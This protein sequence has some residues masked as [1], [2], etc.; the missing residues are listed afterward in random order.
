MTK[1]HSKI[2]K[3]LLLGSGALK[4]GEAGEFDYSGSQAI[5][6][7]KEEGLRVVLVNPNIA[8][9]QTSDMLAD[10]IYFLPVT[11]YFVERVIKKEKPDG[12]LLS[13]GGQTA[14]NCGLELQKKG[15]Y[16]KYGVKVLGTST[17]AIELTEDRQ[18]FADHLRA[19]NLPIPKSQAVNSVLGAIRAAKTIGFP[20]MV[21]AAFALG[22]QKSG[23]AFSQK[24]L[25][26]IAEAAL[27][28][29]PQVLIEKYLHHYKEVE[30][31]VV[32]DRYGNCV[33]V[34][35]MEN[36]DPLGI[37][38]GDSIV[39][40][41]SQTLDN[42][43]YYELRR[44]SMK[45]VRSL[46]IIGECNVQYALNPNPKNKTMDFQVIE[47]NAR[48][49]RS[50]ALASKA[51]GYP[52]AYVA[53]KLAL[54]KSMAEI[55]NQVTKT[56]QSF[57][58]PALDYVVVKF[59]R[60]D[61]EK[62]K[63]AEEKIGSA[64]KSVGEVMAIGRSFEE[65]LQKAVRMQSG[66]IESV[67]DNGLPK[68]KMGIKHF[69]QTPT[70]KRLFAIAE[71]FARGFSVNQIY[72]LTGID[73]WFL[74]RIK[75]IVA[76]EKA[77]IK[78]PTLDKDTIYKLKLLGFSDR[79]IGRLSGKTQ[80]E[81]RKIRKKLGIKP[82]VFQID[83]LAGEA[84]AKTNYL[85]L[86]Y[87]GSHHDV[88]ALGKSGV[89]V[90]GSGPYH[91]G[92]S[93]EFDW[94]CVNTAIALQKLKRKSIIVNC[95][96]E[97]VSTDYDMSDRLYFEDL[98]FETVSD[99]YEYENPEGV[100][101]SVGGQRPNNLAKK[102]VREGFRLLGT[103]AESIDQAEN[104][105]KFSALL[106][107]LNIPQPAWDS[108]KTLEEAEKFAQKVGFPVLVRPSYV[109]SGS[110]MSVCYNLR[111][112]EDFIR[113]AAVV[114]EE[115]PVTI[116]KFIINAKELEFDAV[117]QNGEI[118]VSAIAEHV[119]NAG[120]HSGDATIV[121]PTQRV[122]ASTE[123]RLTEIAK[124]LARELKITGPFNIQFLV[125]DGLPFVI[126]VNVRASRTFPLLSKATGVNF[127]KVC[128][129][130]F[131]GTAKRTVYEYPKAVVVKSPQFSFARLSGADPILQVEM[132]STG[133]VACFGGNYDRALLKSV[134]SANSFDFKKKA[135]LL[136]LGG[137]LNK[138]K[139]L[140][141]A[142]KLE[143]LNYRIFA[144]NT[145][146]EFLK[147]HGVSCEAVR[148]AFQESPNFLDIIENK[149]VS[150]V[151]NLSQAGEIRKRKT[152]KQRITDGY[153]IRRAA[154][155]NHIPLFTD[156]QLARAFVIAL[157]RHSL[158]DLE[159]KSY[160]EYV[161]KF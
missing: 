157:S 48:L 73:P 55:Q 134:L 67:T 86:T 40:A 107:R 63:G 120:V 111:Q 114:S 16:K 103:S 62:F 22:G 140:E 124:S 126:E 96:P 101:V 84:P 119:E 144:T 138:A 90:L 60:W 68:S 33:T 69:L 128:V 27:S 17:R 117:A 116:S 80:F 132:A 31:E 15:V 153:R 5:K 149:T 145:T 6:A 47:V 20:V 32:R 71:A 99:I 53:A 11:S 66:S 41:P 21:R 81:I 44:V 148:K 129:D 118:M 150:F 89:M 3:V 57:F 7:L 88:K 76:V 1:H 2:K 105:N 87:H 100:V 141:A 36:L 137:Q 61:L 91:I 30:Y 75:T 92:S 23:V 102:L 104:R 161:K 70:P 26:E 98:S 83:T 13:F 8:T 34:C 46:G 147:G 151:V 135:V 106:D 159:I 133:E 14:L 127:P 113:K 152:F 156:L 37:H 94:S 110:A 155:D 122:F 95:N 29:S 39:V 82:F 146:A 79:K 139:F 24:Q 49:S 35:N 18:K 97:T 142:K 28:V 42:F 10:E 109:L 50:S 64:M 59:P 136:A 154:V 12:I 143:V 56:T 112:L 131:Y 123:H 160:N 72:K 45:I 125:K 51:T 115:Y 9:I 121:F 38:T 77:F 19:L 43:E 93:V 158:E 25:E 130:A 58:E 4:I 65:A 54:G 52:L 108:F 85:Y 78:K 74:H